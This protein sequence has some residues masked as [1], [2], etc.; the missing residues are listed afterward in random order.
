MKHSLTFLVSLAY[1]HQPKGENEYD[2]LA[3]NRSTPVSRGLL[4]E[5][6]K[7]L[8]RKNKPLVCFL[9]TNAGHLVKLSQVDYLEITPRDSLKDEADDFSY[10]QKS[11]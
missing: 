6:Y 2:P 5:R 11:S 3:E 9:S 7:P 4:Y 8:R 1:S 10:L